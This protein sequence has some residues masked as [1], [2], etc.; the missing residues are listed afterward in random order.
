MVL[1]TSLLNNQQYKVRI[2]GKMQQSRKR[3]SHQLDCQKE[4]EE[5]TKH[6]LYIEEL[7]IIFETN[8]CDYSLMFLLIR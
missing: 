2:K 5:W 1:D 3:S 6:K 7:D 8:F 4:R